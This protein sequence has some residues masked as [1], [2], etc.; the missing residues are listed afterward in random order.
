MSIG[1]INA[2]FTQVQQ[3][4][5]AVAPPGNCVIPPPNPAAMEVA[6]LK[7]RPFLQPPSRYSSQ[8][9]PAAVTFWQAHFSWFVLIEPG[10]TPKEYHW[11]RDG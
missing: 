4:I 2:L 6:A 7:S 1:R 8:R 11:K 3:P 5:T 10:K 9:I